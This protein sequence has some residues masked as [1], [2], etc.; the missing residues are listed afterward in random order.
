MRAVAIT[1]GASG[2]GLATAAL[3]VQRGFAPWLLD[4]KAEALGEACASLELPAGRGIVCNVADE[5]SV[6]AALERVA[7]CGRLVGVVN[8]A[9]IAIDRPMVETSVEDFRRI[10]DV[11][12]TGSFIVARAAARIWLARGETGS[13]VNIS[14]ISGMR[15]NKGRS[16]YGASK[17]GVNTMTMVMANE[18][19]PRGI[20]VNAVAPGPIDTP[21][22]RQVHTQDVRAQWNERVPLRRYGTTAEV[23]GAVA[24][25]MSEDAGYVNGQVL[26]VDGGFTTAGLHA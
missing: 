12:L 3:L 15:G 8:S 23:A 2:I 26:A 7:A 25:L 10:V 16:A 1:G 11:N 20:R 14:S 18:L 24:F 17:G 6:A 13:I 22:A 4:L 21:L 19:G 9:G 5:A